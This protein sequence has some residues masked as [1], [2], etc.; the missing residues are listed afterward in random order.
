MSWN[1]KLL[2]IKA[3]QKIVEEEENQESSKLLNE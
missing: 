1:L 3:H 2:N